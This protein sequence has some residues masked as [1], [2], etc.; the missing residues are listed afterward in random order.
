MHHVSLLIEFLRGRP[1]FVF[2]SVALAQAALWLVVPS[3][4]FSSP[5]HDLSMLLAIGHELLLGSERGPPLAF[6][7]AE[8][9]FRIGGVVGVYVLA[10]ICIVVTYYAV[11][12]LGRAIVGIRHAVLAVLLMVGIAAFTVPSPTF[13]PAVLAAPFWA[14]SLLHF[15]RAVGERRYEAWFSLAVCLGL[16]LLS[17]EAG[18]I[19]LALMI[20]FTLAAPNGRRAL[21]RAEPWAAG[22]LLA[23]VVMP[24][25]LWAARNQPAMLASVFDSVPPSGRAGAR[26]AGVVAGT[27]LG[28]LLLIVL[29]SGFPRNKKQSAPEIDRTAPVNQLAKTYVYTFA[30]VPLLV[31]IAAAF[32]LERVGPFAR[33]TPLVV[34]SGLAM[35]VFAGDRVRL[36]RER[37]VSTAWLGLLLIP[38]ALV[39]FSALLVPWVTRTELT[40]AQPARA[41]AA[42]FSDA[43]TK[44]TGKP[45]TYIAG[46]AQLAPMIAV[47]APTRPHVYF[48]WAPEQSPWATV[49]DVKRQG[50]VLV[51]PAPG[52]ARNPPPQLAAQFPGLIPE[53]PQTFERP[54]RGMLPPVRIGWAVIRPAQP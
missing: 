37:V 14:L 45:L 6:W 38:P 35:M 19:L 4:T 48:D 43:F 24:Y 42:F 2:W 9:A 16:L 20:V 21:K 7:L 28:M 1:R 47:A 31:A 26:V 52:T 11:F 34:L 10:Q 15:W 3:L 36:F 46:D 51:W 5:P 27:H 39:A 50:G 53:V 44:R 25:A 12:A 22:L 32:A 13:G 23:I 8:G 33:V 41:E 40:T 54:V 30:L 29:A 17:S 18:V 49:D